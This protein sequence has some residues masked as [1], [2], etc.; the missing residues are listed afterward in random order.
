MK[1][2]KNTLI[3]ILI[4]LSIGFIICQLITTSSTENFIVLLEEKIIPKSCADYLYYDGKKFYL[5]RS[6]KLIDKTNPMIFDSLQ[7][8]KDYWET[9]GKHC[10]RLPVT[11]LAVKKTNLDPTVEYKRE[12]YN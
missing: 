2:N 8:V 9:T 5:Y 3:I 12:C 6:R 4:I 1:F 10:L 7:K 11:N